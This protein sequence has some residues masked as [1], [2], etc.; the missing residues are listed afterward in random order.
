[1]TRLLSDDCYVDGLREK[2][3]PLWATK[4]IHEQNEL[5]LACEAQAKLTREELIKEIEEGIE[6]LLIRTTEVVGLPIPNF[7]IRE[8]ALRKFMQSIKG[9]NDEPNRRTD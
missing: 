9:G 8:T 1:M 7:Y 3:I 4:Y 6:Q 2:S 5:R